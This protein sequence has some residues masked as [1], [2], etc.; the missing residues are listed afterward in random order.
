MSTNIGWTPEPWR[1]PDN[2]DMRTVAALPWGQRLPLDE[3]ITLLAFGVRTLDRERWTREH[4]KIVVAGWQLFALAE[5]GSVEIEALFSGSEAADPEIVPADTF[6]LAPMRPFLNNSFEPDGLLSPRHGDTEAQIEAYKL[7]NANPRE[8]T[9]VTVSVDGL[10]NWLERKVA[11]RDGDERPYSPF[12]Q[13]DT[14]WPSNLVQGHYFF[15]NAVHRVGRRM[16]PSTWTGR[17][18]DG[19]R[20]EHSILVPPLPPTPAPPGSAEESI[21]RRLLNRPGPFT[22]EDWAKARNMQQELRDGDARFKQVVSAIVEA[23]QSDR[24]AAALAP[25]VKAPKSVTPCPAHFWHGSP[26]D[27]ALRIHFCRLNPS[28]PF[29]QRE[30]EFMRPTYNWI[31]LDMAGLGQLEETVEPA[32]QE[33]PAWRQVGEP[34]IFLPE[35]EKGKRGPR[36]KATDEENTRIDAEIEELL[37]LGHPIKSLR[38]HLTSRLPEIVTAMKARGQDFYQQSTLEKRATEIGKRLRRRTKT[39]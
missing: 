7:Y 37:R 8:W 11:E 30:T 20:F 25:Q 4:G 2:L 15:T 36:P 32:W 12:W 13:E 24:L 16:F 26:S 22:T 17:E 3:A 9:R 39:T 33:P 10:R 38:H 31:Y 18:A 28:D 23:C 19:L 27:M 5:C 35:E 29:R 6:R 1:L 14:E 34:A 21:V